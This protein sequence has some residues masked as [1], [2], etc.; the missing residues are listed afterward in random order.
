MG[1]V[2][3]N[4]LFW[5]V[6]SRVV[7]Y[8]HGMHIALTTVRISLLNSELCPAYGSVCLHYFYS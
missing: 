8:D 2:N 4:T 1:V 6:Q 7:G 5:T 3:S